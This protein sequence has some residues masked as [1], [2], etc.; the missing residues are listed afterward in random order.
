[1]TEAEKAKQTAWISPQDDLLMYDRN[2]KFAYSN[3][4][5]ISKFK[6][7]NLNKTTNLIKFVA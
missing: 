6:H 5:Q 4:N 3:L 1:M 2:S 7:V